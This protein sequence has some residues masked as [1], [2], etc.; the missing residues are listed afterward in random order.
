MR[1]DD[2]R[3]RPLVARS[4]DS[5]RTFATIEILPGDDG[6]VNPFTMQ[7]RDYGLL[8]VAEAETRAN[9]RGVDWVGEPVELGRLI[10]MQSNIYVR[11][12]LG[13][14]GSVDLTP[15]LRVEHNPG[16]RLVLNSPDGYLVHGCATE[17]GT[18]GAPLFQRGADGS[19]RVVGVHTGPTY[20]L[21]SNPELQTC[22]KRGRNYGVRIPVQQIRAAIASDK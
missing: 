7:N 16:C 9:D 6:A 13:L 2:N 19:I 20:D 14:H 11:N 21:R 10:V 15:S 4:I 3:R 12:V 8:R 17:H 1:D 18:S 5:P 22:S